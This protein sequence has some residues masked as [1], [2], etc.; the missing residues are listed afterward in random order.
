[1]T[2]IHHIV[3]SCT[4]RKR[5]D[6]LTS[7][8]RELPRT[9]LVRRSQAWIETVSLAPPVATA[10]ELYRGEYWREG[11]EMAAA[12]ARRCLTEVSVVSAGLGLVSADT[13]LP[14]YA[15][16]FARSHPDSVIVTS[17]RD[18]SGDRRRWWDLMAAWA[19]PADGGPRRIADLAAAPG[20]SFVVCVGPDYLDAI[21][22]DLR[23]AHKIVGGDRL[24]IVGSGPPLEGLSDAWV[25]CPGRLRMRLGGSM[26]STGVRAVRMILDGGDGVGAVTP[27]RARTI[28]EGALKDAAP[29]P[30]FERERLSDDVVAE[31]IIED[32][33]SHP[34]TRNKS[35]ALRRL[36]D[37]GRACEQA[38]FGELYGRA[39]GPAG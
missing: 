12:A 21:A 8:L 16:T 4:N 32:A 26:A 5:S 22:D 17:G 36:R 28:I 19:G 37:G 1:M 15:A 34:G 35:A 11:L 39:L 20:S 10:R 38:R 29:L 9:D 7:R 27:T 3:L 18:G 24:V 6:A 25:R 31:W 30:R 13:A 14:S 2:S 23:Q 33:R